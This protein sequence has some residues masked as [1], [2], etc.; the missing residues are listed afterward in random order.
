LVSVWHVVLAALDHSTSL[1]RLRLEC[2]DIR[3]QVEQSTD[4]HDSPG[5]DDVHAEGSSDIGS[6]CDDGDVTLPRS[7]DSNT[8]CLVN[9]SQLTATAAAAAADD[10]G[11]DGVAETGSDQQGM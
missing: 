10:D 7:S 11:G 4:A 6:A 3:T 9:V 8:Q 2:L 1:E 5:G